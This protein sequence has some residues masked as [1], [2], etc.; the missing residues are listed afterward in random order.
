VDER[1]G[2]RVSDLT[3]RDVAPVRRRRWLPILLIAVIS[4]AVVALFAN[5]LGSNSL[6]FKNADEA[7]RDRQDLGTKRFQVQGTVVEGSVAKT[8]VDRSSAVRFT[9]AFNGV[10]ADVVHVGDPA[11]LFKAG[12]PVVLEGKWM[13][14]NPPAPTD[15]STI[16][17]SAADGW[18]FASDRMF[19]K[20]SADYSANKKAR[21]DAAEA[22]G[23]NTGCATTATGT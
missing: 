23:V 15:A 8:E 9:I 5:A 20:H 17:C 10:R 16:S 19:S 11:P 21:L 22:G 4:V 13:Q 12:V 1:E 2:R 18:Y 7:V 14:A 3:P 6:F